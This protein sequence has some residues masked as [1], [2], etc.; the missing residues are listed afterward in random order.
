VGGARVSVI[1]ALGRF[2]AGSGL[3]GRRNQVFHIPPTQVSRDLSLKH[4]GVR[5]N[6]SSGNIVY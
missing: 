5:S 2:D 6:A 4:V 3:K 1:F